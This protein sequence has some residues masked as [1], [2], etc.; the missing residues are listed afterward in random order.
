MDAGII[1]FIKGMIILWSG[2]K[3]DI[4]EGWHLCDGTVGTPDLQN[5]FI[6][7][8]GDTYAV[9]GSG[10]TTTHIHAFT[11]DGHTHEIPAG[12]SIA[13]G[14]EIDGGTSSSTDTGDTDA[15]SSLPPYYALCYIQ[16]L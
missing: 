12:Y 16:K 14:D 13:A 9:A 3:A 5:K 7:G 4:P 10:G 11:T 8:A 15:G 6:V 2:A 1:P